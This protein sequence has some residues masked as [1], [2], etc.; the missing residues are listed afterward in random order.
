MK[1]QKQS[2]KN[3]SQLTQ[4]HDEYRIA[5]RSYVFF[6][7]HDHAVG[8]DLVQ[9]TF[10]KTWIYLLKGG[11]IIIMKAFLYRVLNN[12]IVDEYRKRKYQTVSL[13]I[14]TEKG[15]EVIDTK[16]DSLVDFLDGKSAMRRIAELPKEYRKII[17]MRFIKNLSVGE[18]SHVTGQTKNV[19]SV[20]V[21]RGLQKLRT[22]YMSTALTS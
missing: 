8:E 14:L 11:K 15:F 16:S 19:V 1:S 12:L 20:K 18:I 7:L 6:K 5:L 3:N 21:H 9:D 17:S 22:L 2:L 13:D 4:A 10:K